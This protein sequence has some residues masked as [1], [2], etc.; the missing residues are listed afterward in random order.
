MIFVFFIASHAFAT[1][2][3]Q[4]MP[5]GA[6]KIFLVILISYRYSKGQFLG[7]FLDKW[8]LNRTKLSKNI[9]LCQET[10]IVYGKFPIFSIS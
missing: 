9:I 5:Q 6:R 10:D 8:S 2:S 1:I 7:F 4:S 3:S